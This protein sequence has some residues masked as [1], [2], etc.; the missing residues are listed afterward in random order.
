MVLPAFA[1][2]LLV[3]SGL[4]LDQHRRTWHKDQVNSSLDPRDLRASRAQYLRRMR[5]SGTIGAIGGLLMLNPIVP[6]KPLVF[7]LYV[8]LLVVLCGWIFLLAMVDSFATS[9]RLRRTRRDHA[10]LESK[11]E[12]ELQKYRNRDND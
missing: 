11:L 9:L 4:M 8:L 12:A 10:S 6:R 3:T 7:T 1:L 5:A 2:V